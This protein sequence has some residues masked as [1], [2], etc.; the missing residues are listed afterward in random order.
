MISKSYRKTVDKYQ[1]GDS[2]ASTA[3]VTT[4]PGSSGN[5]QQ[6][7]L[8]PRSPE[9]EC[10]EVPCDQGHKDDKQAA[11]NPLVAVGEQ[12]SAF[13]RFDGGNSGKPLNKPRCESS[14][15]LDCES[16]S[17]KI[18]EV[19]VEACVDDTWLLVDVKRHRLLRGRRKRGESAENA[20]KRHLCMA[21]QG[22]RHL[23]HSWSATKMKTKLV[24]S[25][26][27][28]RL[29]ACR[30]RTNVRV[31]IKGVAGLPKPASK[32]RWWRKDAWE[33]LQHRDLSDDVAVTA[34]LQAW[35]TQGPLTP[36]APAPNQRQ[37][38]HGTAFLMIRPVKAPS[39]ASFSSRF[40][41]IP[42]TRPVPQ[43]SL[44]SPLYLRR[45]AQATIS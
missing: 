24:S 5:A 25:K 11:S 10:H 37:Q 12:I 33:K 9:D 15:P 26:K 39:K 18:Y 22:A 36:P 6:S 41:K 45:K 20:A 38:Q 2:I 28:G 44:T 16:S 8:S 7:S 4:E 32:F 14:T 17:R 42:V 1:S 21:L 3:L 19:V 40:R 31:D 13:L 29:K 34:A 23:F 43:I 27:S 35:V 30:M